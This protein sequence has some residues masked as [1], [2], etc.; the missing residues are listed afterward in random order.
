MSYN[1]S[2]RSRAMQPIYM[3]TGATTLTK[4]GE[5]KYELVIDSEY[6]EVE[7]VLTLSD[8]LNL[9]YKLMFVLGEY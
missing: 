7:V 9:D 1:G 4:I 5:D 6:G 2:E 3:A 8:L